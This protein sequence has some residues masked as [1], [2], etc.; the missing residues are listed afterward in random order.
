MS[1]TN[2]LSVTDTLPDTATT[3]VPSRVT[4]VVCPVPNVTLAPWTRTVSTVPAP[5]VSAPVPSA[6]VS[7]VTCTAPPANTSASKATP[8]SACNAARPVPCAT[9]A[10]S[11]VSPPSFTVMRTSPS[12]A[13][14]TPTPLITS[15]SLSV[16]D[17][18]PLAVFTALR[19]STVVETVMPVAAES[20]PAPPRTT[21]SLI[22]PSS[23]TNVTTSVPTPAST[24]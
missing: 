11:T 18:F 4:V 2:T 14:L 23:E 3:F 19:L 15:V 22:E 6:S 17:T 5:I 10:L 13:A 16:T 24:C 8:S 21:T 9:T 1:S 12:P 7:A 20:L